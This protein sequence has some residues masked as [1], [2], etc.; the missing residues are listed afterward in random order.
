MSATGAPSPPSSADIAA[1]W[2]ANWK[3]GTAIF[4]IGSIGIAL[5]ASLSSLF[6]EPM[7]S[8]FGWSRSQF[9]FA[10]NAT[11]VVACLSPMIGRII[12]RKGARIV[13]TASAML[14]ALGYA[15]LGLLPN[16]LPIFYVAYLMTMLV[17]TPLG[18]MTL[19][20]AVSQIFVKSRG[21]ALAVTRSGMAISAAAMPPVIYFVIAHYGWRAG[22]MTLSG[23]VAV[24][25]LPLCYFLLPR[26]TVPQPQV[27]GALAGRPTTIRSL[28]RNPKV[29]ALCA[30]TGFGYAPCIALLQSFQPILIDK[31]IAP[32]Q[33]ATLIG[34]MGAAA[35]VSGLL[36]G[37]VVDRLWAP[38]VSCAAMTFGIVGC[39]LL[40]PATVGPGMALLGTIALGTAQG[41]QIQV[42]AYL[43]ARY[44]GLANFSTIFGI[45]VMVIAILVPV[46]I[47]L[48]TRMHEA[49]GSHVAGLS[50]CIASFGAGMIAVLGMGRYPREETVP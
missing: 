16:A 31:G 5:W 33:A 29:R 38:L 32:M 26:E 36:G 8:E 25:A 49:F 35:F 9:A 48:I 20:R 42:S 7:R 13:A 39:L 19:N 43:I 2:R 24:V 23:L 4:L 30:A 41:S 10:F 12:D 47:N 27:H 17:G 11:I 6:I 44:V 18:G 28:L 45:A 1:E 46:E 37:V 3:A 21:L 50:L 34:A 40:M 14:L 22:F 15:A